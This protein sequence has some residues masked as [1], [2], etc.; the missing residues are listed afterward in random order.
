VP[1]TAEQL[2][3][4]GFEPRHLLVVAVDVPCRAGREVLHAKWKTSGPKI[5]SGGL[6]AFTVDGRVMYLGMTTALEMVTHGVRGAQA[7]GPQ[8]YGGLANDKDCRPTQTRLRINSLINEQLR[9]SREV[10]HWLL[11]I[12]GASEAEL[13]RRESEL[14]RRWGLDQTGW[15]RRG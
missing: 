11:P 4:L 3:E 2:L 1:S 9:S 5:G 12:A 10:L 14:I 6:Y 13:K 15:N 7:R 8:R